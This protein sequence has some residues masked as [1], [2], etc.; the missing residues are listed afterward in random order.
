MSIYLSIYLS[1][2]T[3]DTSTSA[4]AAWSSPMPARRCSE[5]SFAVGSNVRVGDLDQYPDSFLSRMMFW[6]DPD[7]LGSSIFWGRIRCFWLI[8]F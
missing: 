4:R 8:F 7:F 3:A 2:Y 1:I 5:T 6:L